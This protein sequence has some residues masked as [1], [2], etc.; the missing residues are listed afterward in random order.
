MKTGW[1]AVVLAAA[2]I[3]AL[4]VFQTRQKTRLQDQI[5]A[6]LVK[7]EGLAESLEHARRE[8]LETT[9]RLAT[10]ERTGKAERDSLE[11]ASLRAEVA[12]LTKLLEAT[13][14]QRLATHTRDLGSER[15]ASEA[16]TPTPE[17]PP[18]PAVPLTEEQLSGSQRIALN[19]LTKEVNR[20]NSIDDIDRLKDSLARWDELYVKDA[21]ED[22][23]PVFLLLEGKVRERLEVLERKRAAEEQARE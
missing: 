22:V 19:Q 23:K 15:N 16:E 3:V 17:N 9:N 18:V 11:I 7:A 20:G 4:L 13:K 5:E 14:Q 6:L 8:H 10:L 1:K 21:P 12:K 2:A